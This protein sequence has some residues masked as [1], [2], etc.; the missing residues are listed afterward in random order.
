VIKVNLI[1]LFSLPI[2]ISLLLQ[3]YI[4]TPTF[5]VN[6]ISLPLKLLNVIVGLW[7]VDDDNFM[8]WAK[9]GIGKG[10]VIL[11]NQIC[12]FDPIYYMAK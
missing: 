5:L 8:R 2:L 12:I 7:S 6:L 9:K 10:K 1:A 11:S 3:N 4:K